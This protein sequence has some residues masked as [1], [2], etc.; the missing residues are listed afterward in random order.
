MNIKE[1]IEAIKNLN[2]ETE[3]IVQKD[4]EGNGFSPLCDVYDMFYMPDNTWQGEVYDKNDPDRDMRA[5]PCIV[6]CPTN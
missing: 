3:V 2:P 1:L 5:I 6:L 4:S